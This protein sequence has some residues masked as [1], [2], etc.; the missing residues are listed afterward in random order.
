MEPIDFNGKLDLSNTEGLIYNKYTQTGPLT[1]RV[2][3]ATPKGW[4]FVSIVAN[5]AAITL[6]SNFIKY[7]G[8]DISM[9]ASTTN[10]LQ[11]FYIDNNTIFY[12]NKTV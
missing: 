8:D 6:P 11:A 3:D 4:A 1:I 12:T 9:V 10:H 2:G 5:G 7:G